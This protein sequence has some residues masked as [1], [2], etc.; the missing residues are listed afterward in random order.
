MAEYITIF[1]KWEGDESEWN[2]VT[3]LNKQNFSIDTWQKWASPVWM[4][5][6]RTN[7]LNGY[8]G[9]SEEKDE[10]HICPLQLDIIE[11]CIALWSNKGETVFTPFMG[12]GSE[13]YQAVKM[14]RK[15]I[16]FEL[17]ESYFDLAK[18]N[19]KAVVSEKNQLSLFDEGQ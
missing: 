10:K 3:N 14:E 6:K 15:G 11:R 7:V 12:I 19:L 2:P 1:R 9:A 18:A 5:I 17:K 13:V 8:Q 4:D 16:G